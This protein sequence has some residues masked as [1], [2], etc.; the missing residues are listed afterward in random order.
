M[1][2]LQIV[3]ME[4]LAYYLK[5]HLHTAFCACH[6]HEPGIC[7]ELSYKAGYVQ[8]IDDQHM[9]DGVRHIQ[10]SVVRH[11]HLGCRNNGDVLLT[12]H[13]PSGGRANSISLLS[14]SS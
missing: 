4:L 13:T 12:R 3:V 7:S 10:A 9:A 11:S 14:C 6:L 5:C 8:H 2:H 1:C